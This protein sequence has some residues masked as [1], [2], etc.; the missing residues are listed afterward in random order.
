MILQSHNNEKSM[1]LAQKQKGRAMDQNRISSI[2]PCLYSHLIFDKRAQNTQ[3]RKD[4]FFNKCCWENWISI[5]RRLK[6]DP[7]LSPCTKTNS[8]WIKDL[9]I[10]PDTLKQLQE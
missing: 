8:K 7:C 10:K 1:V 4:S 9:D 3:W 5:C 6:V 2:N